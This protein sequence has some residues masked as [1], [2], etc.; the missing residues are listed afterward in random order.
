M[1]ERKA[2]KMVRELHPASS[3]ITVN[4]PMARDFYT[5]EQFQPR[6]WVKV[7]GTSGVGSMP[8]FSGSW[9]YYRDEETWKSRSNLCKCSSIRVVR[10]ETDYER[11][12][13][14]ARHL[15]P[16]CT[17]RLNAY[18]DWLRVCGR[19][20]YAAPRAISRRRKIA[21]SLRMGSASTCTFSTAVQVDHSD[22]MAGKIEYASCYTMAAR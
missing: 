21:A 8:T 22:G 10:W 15:R 3:S 18:G 7:M 1:A 9:G 4:L 16:A 12:P 6:A 20:I 11:R 5:P 13:H 2:A 14:V 17:E 19:S